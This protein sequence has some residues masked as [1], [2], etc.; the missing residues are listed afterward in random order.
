MVIKVIKVVKVIKAIKV[1]KAS[2]PM[3][4]SQEKFTRTGT[5]ERNL[6]EPCLF[7]P[8]SGKIAPLGHGSSIL[9]AV[10]ATRRTTQWCASATRGR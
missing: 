8:N 2:Q 5:Q 7:M 10:A 3:H 9:M 6:R 1:I 4:V